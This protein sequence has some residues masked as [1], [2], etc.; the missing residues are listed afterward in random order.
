MSR[1]EIE[2]RSLDSKIHSIVSGI[3][4]VDTERWVTGQGKYPESAVENFALY[5]LDINTTYAIPVALAGNTKDDWDRAPDIPFIHIEGAYETSSVGTEA[6]IRGQMWIALLGGAQGH[7]YGCS[8]HPATPD[9]GVWDF[10]PGWQNYLD[11]PVA[12]GLSVYKEYVR[13]D[14]VPD[15][16]H[17]YLT[18]GYGS[19]SNTTYAGCAVTEAND[20]L[21]IYT[22]DQRDLT[23]VLSGLSG[24]AT[25]CY[26]VG[27][28]TGHITS[29]G[30]IAHSTPY[31]FN[32]P[33]S[34]DW[35]LIADAIGGPV[36]HTTDAVLWGPK[37]HT[38]D[39]VLAHYS[40]VYEAALSILTDPLDDTGHKLSIRARKANAI[41]S[42]TLRVWL[43]QG[44]TEITSVDITLTDSFVTTE[45]TL[46]EVEASNIT[47]YGGL[48]VRLQTITSD[49][50]GLTAEV[51]W[52][53]LLIPDS[54]H[55]ST[56]HK[57]DS[58]LTK[59]ATNSASHTTDAV[60]LASEST[61]AHTT[62]AL[63]VSESTSS[64][65]TDALLASEST[66]SHT[67]DAV[68]LASASTDSHTTDALLG[69][70]GVTAHLTDA[71][72][73]AT[74]N[75]DSH[76][77]DALLASEST[78]SHTTD[79]LLYS[80]FTDSH[81][82]D[83]LIA[84]G[85]ETNTTSHTTDS[86]LSSPDAATHL[87]DA[88]LYDENT[89]SHATG[90]L[91][92]SEST[93]SHTVD[94]L[95]ASENIETHTTDA[96]LGAAGV[97]THLTS[98]ALKTPGT[99]SAHTTD[100]LLYVQ[101]TDS[102]TTDALLYVQSIETHTTG[103]ALVSENTNTHNTD[104]VL[105]ATG[106]TSDHATDA[107]LGTANLVVRTTDAILKATGNTSDH[108]VNA[109]L[110]SESTNSHTTD[111][112]LASEST[113]SHTTDASLNKE[114]TDSHT[115]DALV[116]A[117]GSSGHTTGALL[118][119]E[120]TDSHT[121]DTILI[122]ARDHTTNAVLAGESTTQHSTNGLIRA[123]GWDRMHPLMVV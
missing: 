115:T 59:L 65:T 55:S 51:S 69:A 18:V 58:L 98:A 53:E 67:T 23:V 77:T 78:D 101:S 70:S 100:A 66:D 49:P 31:V 60:L 80:Q 17:R 29:V 48:S 54:T 15:Y 87:T 34:G 42:G 27:P 32:P 121:T 57:T 93:E 76:T 89:I 11:Y 85:L 33:S 19:I 123:A 105:K 41:D 118:Y 28:K 111:A 61:D 86:L 2:A 9:G 35:V 20:K 24:N 6:E 63:L 46:S 81:T 56:I 108:A 62:D 120:N 30:I 37:R 40:D 44:T 119:S 73:K 25:N 122:K 7:I 84:V 12:S 8:S 75:T 74:G 16:D 13:T 39:A 103:S 96:L 90:A 10:V 79:A 47:V 94:A 104:T 14:L 21:I 107:A 109:L 116:A 117:G 71:V 102:H 3:L 92:A 22:P 64:H 113:N 88:A 82:T 26:W 97:V 38:T 95:L 1:A 83:A 106:N 110:A 52:V 99:T 91:L 112:L 4:S 114:N 5:N 36:T 68:L 50:D 72:L 45:H 43:M